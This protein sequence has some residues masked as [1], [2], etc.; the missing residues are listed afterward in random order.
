MTATVINAM[1]I[2]M[3]AAFDSFNL[4]ILLDKSSTLLKCIIKLNSIKGMA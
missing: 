1:S 2:A 3:F 4:K